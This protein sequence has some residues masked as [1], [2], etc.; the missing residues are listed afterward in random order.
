VLYDGEQLDAVIGAMTRR[1]AALLAGAPRIT[2]VGILRRGAPLAERIAAGLQREHGIGPVERLDLEIKRYAD[3]LTLLHPETRLTESPADAGLDLVG[4]SVLLV[5]DVLYTGHS[6]LRA[7]D[8]LRR[9]NPDRL[10]T[11]VLVDRS[12]GALPVRMDITGARL[13]AAQG[14]IVE[15]RA[16][17]YEPDWGI[18]VLRRGEA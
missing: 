14:D 2:V 6:M 7:M 11:A 3:D 13:E 12:A 15:C 8:Y 18:H 1:A 17:P 9:K 5:D 16:P 10:F 4:S